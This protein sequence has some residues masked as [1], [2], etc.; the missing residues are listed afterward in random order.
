MHDHHCSVVIKTYSERSL[1]PPKR[2][3]PPRSSAAGQSANPP[4]P[5][6]SKLARENSITAAQEEEIREAFSLFAVHVKPPVSREQDEDMED[7]DA[8]LGAGRRRRRGKASA[9]VNEDDDGDDEGMTVLRKEDVRRC[10][11]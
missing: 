3:A 8:V 1:Q 9:T 11:M 6:R 10:L 5:K 7:A 2:R 4:V